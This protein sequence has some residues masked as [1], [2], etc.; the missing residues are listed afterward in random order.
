LPEWSKDA[1]AAPG[2]FPG[3]GGDGNL[4]VHKSTARCLTTSSFPARHSTF[5]SR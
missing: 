2:V 1:Y 3:T 5:R 4:E